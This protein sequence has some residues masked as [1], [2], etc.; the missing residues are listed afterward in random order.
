VLPDY[1]ARRAVYDPARGAD[2]RT[3]SATG[4]A[5]GLADFAANAHPGGDGSARRADEHSRPD[6]DARAHCDADPHRHARANTDPTGV[7][8]ALSGLH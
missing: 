6:G 3:D 1:P 2:E 4:R 5:R 8:D 7:A